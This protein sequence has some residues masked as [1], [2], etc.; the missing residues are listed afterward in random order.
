MLSRSALP[1]GLPLNI[2]D[3][4]ERLFNNYCALEQLLVISV[5]SFVVSNA[6]QKISQSYHEIYD[7][8]LEHESIDLSILLSFI[9]DFEATMPRVAFLF[10]APEYQER[11]H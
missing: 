8:L 6:I 3:A 5:E 4:I 7:L 9:S 2:S 10:E 1:I 11:T